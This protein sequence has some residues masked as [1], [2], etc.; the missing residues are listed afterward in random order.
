VDHLANIEDIS[1]IQLD[2]R[3]VSRHRLVKQII[4][5]YNEKEKQ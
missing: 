1:M 4:D 2:T 5:A 3:D